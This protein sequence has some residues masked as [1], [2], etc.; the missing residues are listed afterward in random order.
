MHYPRLMI[1]LMIAFGALPAHSMPSE[2][3][4][5]CT[6]LSK[7]RPAEAL[8]IAE[9]SLKD[10]A[11]PEAK[12]CRALS[13]F[14]LKRYPEAAEGLEEVFTATPP[15]EMALSVNL[16]RQAARARHLAKDDATARKRYDRAIELLQTAR[17]P[18]ALS[19]RLLAETLLERGTWLR[20]T[21][22]TL[23]ALQDMDYAVTLAVLGERAYIARARLLLAMDQPALAMQDAEAALRVTPSSVEAQRLLKEILSHSPEK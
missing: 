20:N 5:N 6:A 21:G 23:N 14:S 10:G 9:N 12:H 3:Y 1:G 11:S 22:D 8:R 18:S 15:Q 13:L 17:K 19:Q 2:A 7:T 4:Q 16:L